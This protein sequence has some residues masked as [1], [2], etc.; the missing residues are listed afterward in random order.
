[1]VT[2]RDIFDNIAVSWY[3]YHHHSRFKNELED[4]ARNWRGGRLLNVGC[5]HGPDFLPFK[6]K[7][8]L[9]GLD[10]SAGMIKQAIKYASKYH[11]KANLVIADLQEL[12]FQDSVFDYTIA[13]ASYHHVKGGSNV[14]NA[15]LELRRVLKTD[16]EVFITV[17]NKWQPRFWFRGKEVNV[18]WHTK[19]CVYQ[20]Y[21]YLY[22]KQEIVNLLS[23]SGFF[24]VKITME[25]PSK[26]PVKI[27]SN[28][29]CLLAKAI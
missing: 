21:Y 20:R 3:G 14:L 12:P 8:E 5:G 26:F 15:F 2:N 18:P 9:Y 19:N 28:N 24:V 16:A 10:F 17:W 22:S 29:I 25:K 7:F 11:F 23:R 1:M 13:I 6:E 4:L 27:F